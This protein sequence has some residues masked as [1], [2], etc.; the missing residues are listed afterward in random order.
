VAD[1]QNVSFE[2]KRLEYCQEENQTEHLLGLDFRK[3]YK[4]MN[5]P[6]FSIGTS[7]CWIFGT[8][9]VHKNIIKE[10]LGILQLITTVTGKF[11]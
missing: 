9:Y 6:R 5:F 2:H 7:V 3:S 10:I 4:N 11:N 1:L 8:Y